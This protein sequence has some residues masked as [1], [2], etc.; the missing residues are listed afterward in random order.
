MYYERRGISAASG[1]G[2]SFCEGSDRGN[3]KS[4]DL[5]VEYEAFI[6]LLRS[7]SGIIREKIKETFGY[8]IPEEEQLQLANLIYYPERHLPRMMKQGR[9]TEDWQRITIYR[10][11]QIC[12]EVASK[13]TRSKVRKKMPKEYAYTIDENKK[14]Y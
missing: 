7:S 13:Y 4:D 1:A 6:H 3:R 12:R 10:L 11:V 2:I 5:H 14:L 8:V 9:Y